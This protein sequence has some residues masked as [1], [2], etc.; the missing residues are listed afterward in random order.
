[1]ELENMNIVEKINL[2]EN[3]A[4][5][6]SMDTEYSIQCVLGDDKDSTLSEMNVVVQNARHLFVG[7]AIDQLD[8]DIRQE[9]FNKWNG[10]L[11]ER[12]MKFPEYNPELTEGS[13]LGR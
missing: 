7:G 3:L 10:I 5:K 12:I 8:Y 13:H 11:T 4:A 6:A 2:L 9:S 1:M